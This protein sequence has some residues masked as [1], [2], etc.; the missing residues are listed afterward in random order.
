M[1]FS[2]EHLTFKAL[3]ALDE[4]AESAGPVPKSFALRF[5][6]AFLYATSSGDRW[7]FDEFW[8]RATDAAGPDY[9][10]AMARRQSLSAC[11]NGI[12]RA[13]GMERTPELIRS[14]REARGSDGQ[15]PV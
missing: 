10:S 6:L 8:R 11:L 5:A 9:V 7:L 15:R 13:A 3:L 1:R 14:F 2:K 12:C 4:A